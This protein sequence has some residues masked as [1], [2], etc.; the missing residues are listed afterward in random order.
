MYMC[1]RFGFVL[2][3]IVDK[4]RF[5]CTTSIYINNKNSATFVRE[6]GE[7]VFY[8]CSFNSTKLSGNMTDKILI[9]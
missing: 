9:I 3:I 1:G 2:L 4:I 6:S 7:K 5:Y 8:I